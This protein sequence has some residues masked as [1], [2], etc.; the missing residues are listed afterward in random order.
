MSRSVKPTLG[1]SVVSM[2]G[3]IEKIKSIE[4]KHFN[5]TSKKTEIFC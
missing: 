1:A 5:A 2:L 4:I 3:F